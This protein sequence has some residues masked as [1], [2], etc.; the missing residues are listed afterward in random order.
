MPEQYGGL[1]KGYLDHTI[2]MEE[3]S[4][5]SGSIALSYGAQ[6]VSSHV[7][8][9]MPLIPDPQLESLRQSDQQERDRSAEEEVPAGPREREEGRISGDERAG[10]RIGRGVDEA[11]G[12]EERGS[13]HFE[14]QQILVRPSPPSRSM[15][16]W[17]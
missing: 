3:L 2:V 1:N 13:L 17:G 16:G 7:T 12:R 14:R 11:A 6:Y 15:D 4:R 9:A 10:K 8:L 5:A